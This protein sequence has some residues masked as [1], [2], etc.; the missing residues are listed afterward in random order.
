MIPQPRPLDHMTLVQSQPSYTRRHINLYRMFFA[1]FSVNSQPIFMKL[2]RGDCREIF[3]EKY[4]IA[5]NLDHLA[6]R[7]MWSKF[8]MQFRT[9]NKLSFNPFNGFIEGRRKYKCTTCQIVR[10][11]ELWNY[12]IFHGSRPVT[13]K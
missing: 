6:C 10:M 4:R 7:L 1:D 5:T 13:R 8:L 12:I 9:K 3:I 2:S 11:V